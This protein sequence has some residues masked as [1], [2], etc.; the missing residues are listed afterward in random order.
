MRNLVV[1]CYDSATSA[2]KVHVPH[3]KNDL[4]KLEFVH[5]KDLDCE[6]TQNCTV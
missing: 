2:A 6:G 1:L 5:K 3:F 4:D